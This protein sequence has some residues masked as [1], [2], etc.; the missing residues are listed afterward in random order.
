MFVSLDKKPRHLQAMFA[1]IFGAGLHV[2]RPREVRP[3]SDLLT[4]WVNFFRSRP[5]PTMARGLS[6]IRQEFTTRPIEPTLV[7]ALNYLRA[8][9]ICRLHVRNSCDETW[10]NVMRCRLASLETADSNVAPRSGPNSAFGAIIPA[11]V[12]SL[13]R[14]P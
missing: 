8:G 9:R 6:I 14:N 7:A 3:P 12:P 5:L 10:T 2:D 1:N 11:S 13:V 4:A